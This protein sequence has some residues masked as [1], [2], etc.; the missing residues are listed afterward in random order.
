MT[1][2]SDS[3]GRRWALRLLGYGAALAG[4]VW[5][6]HDVRPADAVRSMAG[7][8]WGWIAVAVACDVASYFSQ[9]VRWSL[10]LRPLGRLS[11]V[12][13]TQAVYAALFTNEMLP[14]RAGEIL[15][16]YLVSRWLGLDSAAVVSSIAVERLLDGVWL[17]L[18]IALTATLV[19]LPR[20]LVIGEEVLGMLVLLGIIVLALLLVRRRAG[21]TAD[22]SR[23]DAGLE[24]GPTVRPGAWA[25]AR[26]IVERLLAA[27]HR[28]GSSRTLYLALAVSSLVLFFQ[29][30]S[31]WLVLHACGLGL[32]F[33]Q[34][35]AVF[36]I[37]HLGT[38]LPNAPSN[39][40]TYQ[41]FCVVG[42]SLFGVNK[43]A[44]AGFSVAVFLILTLPLWAL[45]LLALG[46]GGLSLATLRRDVLRISR[47][48]S[49]GEPSP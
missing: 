24:A 30:L 23:A 16:V 46:R 36:L 22:G 32:S 31:F 27:L 40:G 44:A 38:A 43:T 39:V 28:I 49:S 34:G 45:G 11:P 37:V 9:G 5:V 15:R 29:M 33:W 6:F 12:R 19:P 10:L 25:R 1:T 48:G 18:A 21:G 2:G 41:F 3:P 4:L 26:A 14:L 47:G 13:A 20:D 35:A 17:A 8:R 42:L 7:I